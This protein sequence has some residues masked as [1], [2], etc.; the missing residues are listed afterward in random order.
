MDIEA[1]NRT[2]EI[3]LTS[4]GEVVPV[5]TF[6]GA[7]GE[8]CEPLDAVSFVAGSDEAGWFAGSFSNYEAA[9]SH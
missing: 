6:I 4:C 3:A 1:V 5:T 9:L 7:D 2:D 8:E